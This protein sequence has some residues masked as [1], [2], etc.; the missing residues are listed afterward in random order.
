M[1]PAIPGYSVEA[2]KSFVFNPG[3]LRRMQ[4]GAG[5]ILDFLQLV[6]GQG[7]LASE[8]LSEDN[9]KEFIQQT[10]K[11]QSL[12]ICCYHGHS[13]MGATRFLIEQGFEQVC[14]LMGG[15]EEWKLRYPT[16]TASGDV[17]T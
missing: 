6:L 12:I 17:A 1:I 16:S 3:R 8:L 5:I 9:L 10:P 14:S 11:S 2:W 4:E 13:S 7:L 15:F